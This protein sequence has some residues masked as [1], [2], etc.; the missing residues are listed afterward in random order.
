M[1]PHV[2]LI[3]TGHFYFYKTENPHI[4]VLILARLPSEIFLLFIRSRFIYLI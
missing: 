4:G 3:L 2:F 1:S